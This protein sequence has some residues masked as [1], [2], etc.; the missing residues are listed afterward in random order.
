MGKNCDIFVIEKLYIV[1]IFDIVWTWILN[2]LTVLDYGW[3]CTEF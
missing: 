3:T 1:N 2:F